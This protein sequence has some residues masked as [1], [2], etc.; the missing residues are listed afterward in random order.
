MPQPD[1]NAYHD[2]AHGSHYTFERDGENLIVDTWLEPGGILP[3]HFH[4]IQEEH[5]AVV[6][7]AVRVTLDGEKRELVPADGAVVV[8]PYT[9]H[10]LENKGSE[11]IHARCHVYPAL[12]LEEFLKESSAAAQKGYVGK[13]GIPKSWKGAKWGAAFIKKHR[14]ETVI[15][16]PPPFLQSVMIGLLARD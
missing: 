11:T 10:S 13:G 8:K 16:F 5:W 9:R 15:T 7:G 6:E 2:P 1:P 3:T 4:P 12:H 14:P